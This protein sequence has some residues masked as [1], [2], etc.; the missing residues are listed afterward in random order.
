MPRYNTAAK[1]GAQ[2]TDWLHLD[3]STRWTRTDFQRPA[4][5][6]NSLYQ[7]LA[8][9][10]WPV[11]PLQDRNG[12]YYSAPSPA[13]GLATAG[14]DTKERD[15]LNQQVNLL[16]EPIKNW[17]THIDFTYRSENTARHWDK[18]MLYNHDV[19]GNPIVYDKGSNVHEDE[20][21]AA[22]RHLLHKP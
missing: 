19:A 15:I 16:I 11:L 7:D 1:I 6:T 5:L 18:K 8:R 13:L 10:G 22:S 4:N 20:Y 9:Q 21:K 17:R 3:Y 12:Y 2:I 14:K